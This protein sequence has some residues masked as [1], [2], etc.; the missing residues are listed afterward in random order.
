MVFD[1]NGEEMGARTM[2][3]RMWRRKRKEMSSR[4]EGD[5]MHMHDHEEDMENVM[6]HVHTIRCIWFTG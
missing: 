6:M 2:R 3:R 5:H 1:K 4:M